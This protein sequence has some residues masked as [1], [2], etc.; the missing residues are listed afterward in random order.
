MTQRL[1]Q[2]VFRFDGAMLIQQDI[3][4]IAECRDQGGF[5]P[6]CVSVGCLGV[7]QWP[8]PGLRLNFN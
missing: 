6:E 8:E 3:A 5:A 1:L 2:D 4:Q 7:M